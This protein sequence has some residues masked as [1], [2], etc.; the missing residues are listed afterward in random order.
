MQVDAHVLEVTRDA[1]S[2]V[3]CS[4]GRGVKASVAEPRRRAGLPQDAR[5]FDLTKERVVPFFCRQAIEAA[6]LESLIWRRHAAAGIA[7]SETEAAIGKALTIVGKLA[8]LLLDDPRLAEEA[9]DRCDLRISTRPATWWRTSQQRLPCGSL[10]MEPLTLINRTRDPH[11]QAPAVGADGMSID[12]LKGAR[13]VLALASLG[14]PGELF[15]RA[16]VLL[17]R[18]ALEKSSLDRFWAWVP[19]DLQRASTR[20]QLVGLALIS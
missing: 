7:R 12:A 8:L 16:A 15:Q 6:C 1:N 19:P 2:H 20:A 4:R 3:V 9:I 5:G 13:G 11:G 17:T 10:S 14:E 18:Q